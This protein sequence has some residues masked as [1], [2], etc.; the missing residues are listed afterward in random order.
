MTPGWAHAGK[1]M[2]RARAN[3]VRSTQLG[4]VPGPFTGTAT[5]GFLSYTVGETG[6]LKRRGPAKPMAGCFS[7]AH[8]SLT[9]CHAA[10]RPDRRQARSDRGVQKTDGLDVAH[11]PAGDE[12][13]WIIALGEGAG[14]TVK[15]D[16]VLLR[17]SPTQPSA[18]PRCSS[19]R[20]LLAKQ[21]PSWHGPKANATMEPPRPGQGRP[22]PVAPLTTR[23]VIGKPKDSLPSTH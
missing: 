11:L 22:R 23:G 8:S 12:T 2:I 21:N 3:S 19:C 9:K 7:R 14:L 4:Q 5:A 1:L 18:W 13:L 6:V 20:R 10:D 17:S 15:N 16:R